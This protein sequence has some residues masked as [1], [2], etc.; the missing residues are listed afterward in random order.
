MTEKQASDKKNEL[1][2]LLSLNVDS[3]QRCKMILTE[4]ISC[5]SFRDTFRRKLENNEIELTKIQSTLRDLIS[6]S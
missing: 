5:D 6:E 1:K 3:L 2:K 4:L